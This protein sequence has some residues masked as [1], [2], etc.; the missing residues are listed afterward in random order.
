[1]PRKSPKLL[2]KDQDQL[3]RLELLRLASELQPITVRGLYT[4][5]SFQPCSISSPRT[6]SAAQPITT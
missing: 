3:L 1:M 6:V 5:Q 2:T 4:K